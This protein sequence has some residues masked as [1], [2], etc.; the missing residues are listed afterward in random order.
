MIRKV[1][2]LVNTSEIGSASN[3]TAGRMLRDDTGKLVHDHEINRYM[4]GKRDVA[5]VKEH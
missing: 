3:P 1:K 2:E 5:S 4:P